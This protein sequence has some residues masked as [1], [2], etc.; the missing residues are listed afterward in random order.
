ME[1]L[2]KAFLF[3]VGAVAVVY[4]ETAKAVQTQREKLNE[5][6]SKKEA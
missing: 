2:R 4:E 6:F 5:R 1:M 3:Y